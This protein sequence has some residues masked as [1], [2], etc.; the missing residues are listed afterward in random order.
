MLTSHLQRLALAA[1]GSIQGAVCGW[2]GL[3][4]R[5]VGCWGCPGAS[6]GDALERHSQQLMGRPI[7]ESTKWLVW[8]LSLWGVHYWPLAV[9]LLA[10]HCPELTTQYSGWGQRNGPHWQ[11]P[12]QLVKP[13]THMFSCSPAGEI[14]GQEGLSWHWALPPCGRDGM[15]SQT[16][17]LTLLTG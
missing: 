8:S 3:W 9:L 1:M 6:C 13:S 17:P 12:T 15:L 11:R 2:E 14:T 5:H 7:I 10:A 4:V 16:F